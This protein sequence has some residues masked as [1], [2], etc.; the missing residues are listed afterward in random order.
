MNI[1]KLL[2]ELNIKHTCI[3][4]TSFESLGLLGANVNL[5]LCSFLADVKYLNIIGENTSVLLVPNEMTAV[6]NHK[7]ICKVDDPRYTF[8]LLHN[9][10]LQNGEYHR[11]V[12][13]T[14]IGSNCK[15]SPLA[16]IAENNVILGNNIVIEEFVSIKENVT[17]GDN[18]IIR[19]GTIIGGEGFEQKRKSDTVLSLHHA[20]GVII[21][22]N[23]ELQQINAV[24]KAIYPWDNTIIGDYCRTDN[25][26]HIAHGV[27]M[28]KR[29]LIAACTCVA[30]RVQMDDDVWIGPG[31]TLIN[32][33]HIG[34]GARVNI[35][36][37]A[38]RDVEP[39]K[40]VTGNFAIDHDRFISNLKSIR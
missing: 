9:H 31:V 26:V 24:D 18:T 6:I 17:I 13:K 23:V 37:V 21:G 38:T 33:M 16:H 34:K 7:G 12:F 5:K 27:K 36:S 25:M 14:R 19:A 15:I 22:S 28:G 1:D 32:G 40:A 30:G 11:P 10:L 2:N 35:G 39:G 29:I 3:G 8:F 20:G 4:E